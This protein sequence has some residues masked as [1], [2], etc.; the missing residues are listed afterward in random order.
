MPLELYFPVFACLKC[1]ELY[2]RK[3][4]YRRHACIV[5]PMPKPKMDTILVT[6]NGDILQIK[7]LRNTIKYNFTRKT[8]FW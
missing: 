1:L 3:D 5:T 8:V 4:T 6:Y 2:K 7:L